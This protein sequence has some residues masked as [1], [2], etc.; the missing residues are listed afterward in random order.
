M[1][2]EGPGDLDRVFKALGNETRRRILRLL[3]QRAHY[4][5]ELSTML[6]LTP[7]G[8]FKHLEALQKAGLVEREHGESEL[9]PDRVYYRLNIR[10]GLSTTILPGAFAVRVTRHGQTGRI[11]IPHGFIIPEARPDVAA[12]RR[13]LRELGRVNKRLTSLDQEKLRFISLRGQ[14]IRQIETIMDQAHWDEESCQK[15][16]SLLDPVRQQMDESVEADAWTSTVQEALRLFERMLTGQ[17]Q[18]KKKSEEEDDNEIV[19]DLE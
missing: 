18:E 11:M 10:F 4:P 12:V 3:A 19:L 2:Q 16:R 5:Y 14:I 6:G 17:P 9:G 15:V 13:L 1:S 8:V 7:R